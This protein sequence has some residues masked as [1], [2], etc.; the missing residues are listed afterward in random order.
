M[1]E[2]LTSGT[3]M[4]SVSEYT[5]FPTTTFLPCTVSFSANQAFVCSG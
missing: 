4:P 2:P 1:H 5:R 3:L